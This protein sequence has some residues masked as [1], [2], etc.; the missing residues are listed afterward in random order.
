MSLTTNTI[1]GGTA[2][3]QRLSMANVDPFTLVVAQGVSSH[4]RLSLL[5]Q[6]RVHEAVQG[7]KCFS[8]IS[9]AV[10][11]GIGVKHIIRTLAETKE[12]TMCLTLCASLSEVF[13]T[14]VSATILGELASV[15]G[16]PEGSGPSLP[17][18]EHLVVACGGTLAATSFPSVAEHIMGLCD[19]RHKS[20]EFPDFRCMSDFNDVAQALGGVVEILNGSLTSITLVGGAA[21]GWIASFA[22]WFLGLDIEIRGGDEGREILYTSSLDGQAAISVIYEH[23]QANDMAMKRRDTTYIL[24]ELDSAMGAASTDAKYFSGRVPWDRALITAFGPQARILIQTEELG[25]ML[26]AAASILLAVSKAGSGVSLD[27]RSAAW[28]GY[29]EMSVGFGFLRSAWNWLPELQGVSDAA[30]ACVGEPAG[31]AYVTFNKARDALA[32]MCACKVCVPGSDAYNYILPRTNPCLPGLGSTI[33]ILVWSLASIHLEAPLQPSL[34]GLLH[35]DNRPIRRYGGSHGTM[36]N[37]RAL[38]ADPRKLTDL[39]SIDYVRWIAATVLGGGEAAEIVHNRRDE[40]SAFTNTGICFYQGILRDLTDRPEAVAVLHIVPGCIQTR[41]GRIGTVLEDVPGIHIYQRTTPFSSAIPQPYDPSLAD[42]N[43][44]SNLSVDLM[45][46]ETITKVFAYFR[47]TSECRQRYD[48][49][50]AEH[51]YNILAAAGKVECNAERHQKTSILSTDKV[52]SLDGEGTLER[53]IFGEK[54]LSI[55]VRRLSRNTLARC[56]ALRDARTY[57]SPYFTILRTHECLDCCIRTA[58]DHRV[59]DDLRDKP[60]RRVVIIA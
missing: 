33:V 8:S 2:I 25:T 28:A 12:G 38:F 1:T 37:S 45:I 4:F 54:E 44:G 39:L 53:R 16:L 13:G 6:R 31:H 48:I 50:P 3:L 59:A 14:D 15:L 41:A 24:R 57:N 30:E 19:V 51:M 60:K 43:T 58:Q 42:D 9:N 32:N 11:F 21:C 49:G 29:G 36:K 23:Y 26:G 40:R 17:Q 47:L 35:L 55:I 5:G 27:D 34:R 20:W 10:W 56:V 52:I 46:K 22:H 18:W 7:L